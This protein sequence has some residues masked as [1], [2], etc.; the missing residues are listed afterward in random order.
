M[1]E[2]PWYRLVIEDAM[3]ADPVLDAIRERFAQAGECPGRTG[4]F[5]R[6]ESEGRLHCAVIIH[7]TPDARELAMQFGATA[8]ARPSVSGLHLLAGSDAAWG[9]FPG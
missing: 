8:C 5:M 7:F 4:V 1:Q 9:L 3:L 2:S 6:H